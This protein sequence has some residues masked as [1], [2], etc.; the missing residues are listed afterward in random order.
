MQARWVWFYETVF[1]ETVGGCGMGSHPGVMVRLGVSC[2]SYF[3][4]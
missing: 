4:G 2:G 1:Y 3:E